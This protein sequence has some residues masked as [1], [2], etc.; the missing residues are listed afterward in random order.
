MRAST[1]E[2]SGAPCDIFGG[3]VRIVAEV[4][5]DEEDE[6]RRRRGKKI[7]VILE[8]FTRAECS[9]NFTALYWALLGSAGLRFA[10]TRKVLVKSKSD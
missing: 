9:A 8:W 2:K 3:S 6:E 10:R 7:H 4:E 5:K 1:R